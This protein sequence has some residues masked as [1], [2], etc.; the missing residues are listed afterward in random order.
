M[1]GTQFAKL[2]EGRKVSIAANYNERADRERP[3]A[4]TGSEPIAH[5]ARFR[6]TELNRDH[7]V[8]AFADAAFHERSG[9]RESA[10]LQAVRR[11]QTLHSS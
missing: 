7:A 3:M 8:F 9:Y 11:R 5:I 6:E 4:I 1:S 10:M 2:F